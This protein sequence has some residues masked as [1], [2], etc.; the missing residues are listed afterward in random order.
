MYRLPV[1]TINKDD[2][3]THTRTTKACLQA[4][5]SSTDRHSCQSKGDGASVAI[6]LGRVLASGCGRGASLL[7]ID[8]AEHLIRRSS[9]E[10]GLEHTLHS[11]DPSCWCRRSDDERSRRKEI[12][13]W[14]SV[15][16]WAERQQQFIGGLTGNYSQLEEWPPQADN[17]ELWLKEAS[18]RQQA[19]LLSFAQSYLLNHA[20]GF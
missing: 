5:L 20:I 6:S 2:Y 9:K 16:S 3:L 11:N 7:Q 10:T 8:D 19:V 15:N 14:K 13:R 1:K 17:N 12:F 4:P 18:G